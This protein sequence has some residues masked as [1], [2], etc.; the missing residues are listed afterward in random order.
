[1]SPTKAERWRELF[2]SWAEHPELASTGSPVS[3]A[4]LGELARCLGHW[5]DLDGSQELLDVG[6]ASGRLTRL[7][8]RGTAH[9]TGLDASAALIDVAQAGSEDPALRFVHGDATALPFCD[10]SFDLVCSYAMLLCLPDHGAVRRA[11]AEMLR[12]TRHDCCILLGSLPDPRHKQ[13]FA[14][15]CER[16]AAWYRRVLGRGLRRGIR[17]LLHPGQDPEQTEILWF[18]IDDLATEMRDRGFVVDV[19][20]DPEYENYRDYRRSLLLRRGRPA[21]RS[22]S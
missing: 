9:T 18:D 14:R 8:A 11:I 10:A 1:M 15:H 12:V 21:C 17:K 16:G 6:C 22:L 5:L 13:A 7:L 3:D 20:V 19:L 2:D 4:E